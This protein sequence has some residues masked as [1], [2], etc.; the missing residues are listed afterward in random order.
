MDQSTDTTLVTG[1]PGRIIDFVES[2]KLD[3]SGVRFFVLDEA[4]R[5][6]DTGED[7]RSPHSLVHWSIRRS[8]Y[9]YIGPF[10]GPFIGTLAHSSVHLLVHWSIR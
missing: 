3:V 9:W 5:L 8:I 2:G 1:T 7:V 4:D 6:L 10:V